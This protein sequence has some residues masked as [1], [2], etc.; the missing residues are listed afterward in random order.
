MSA[1]SPTRSVHDQTWRLLEEAGE[2]ARAVRKNDGQRAPAGEVTG[3]ID[4]E[5]V[6][7]LI[8][9]CSIANRLDLDLA[10]ALRAKEALN[11][12]RTWPT[13]TQAPGGP[14]AH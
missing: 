12:T 3:S 14:P 11:E 2:L 5:L 7:I 1:P 13:T 6:D 8:F 9:A 10:D 4:E